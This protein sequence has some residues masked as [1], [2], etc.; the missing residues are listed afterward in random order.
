VNKIPTRS[1]S[2]P[3][4]ER[5][6]KGSRAGFV[7]GLK[8]NI[9]L[10]RN[11]IK[12]PN[13]K[14][15]ISPIGLRSRTNVAIVYLANLANPEVV[16]EVRSRLDSVDIDRVF[17]AGQLEV[18]LQDTWITLFPLTETTER[19]DR[20]ALAIVAGRVVIVV[21]GT[22]F[23]IIVPA[24]LNYMMIS[25]EDYNQYWLPSS[26]LRLFRVLGTILSLLLPPFYIALTSFHPEMFPVKLLISI[27]TARLKTPFPAIVEAIGMEVAIEIIR[28]AGLRL[29][30]PLGQ[31]IGVVGV[32]VVGQAAIQASLVSPLLLIVVALTT[33]SSFTIPAYD[34]ASAI[35]FLRFPMMLMAAFFGLYGIIIG[36]SVVLAHLVTLKS[37]GAYYLSPFA[38]QRVEE[39][40]DS[41]IRLPSMFLK[42]RP[43]TFAPLDTKRLSDK[44]DEVIGPKE[45][46]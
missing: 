16:D 41:V 8:S 7:E 33:I 26:A 21:D 32:I 43:Q 34:L 28:E 45:G 10:L 27:G 23:V 44:R 25:P 24:T 1:V 11:V 36:V 22:P 18:F 46:E 13:L 14:V 40:K 20:T 6:I 29:P 2:E 12:D 9:A 15:R 17:A 38:P 4:S 35:R 3:T 5:A 31:T 39:M 42:K 19:V 37:F 30:A